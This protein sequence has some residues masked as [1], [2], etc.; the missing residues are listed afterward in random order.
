MSRYNTTEEKMNFTFINQFDTIAASIL[1]TL[2]EKNDQ[3]QLAGLPTCHQL[4]SISWH[5]LDSFPA[6][7]ENQF[8]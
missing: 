5:L 6:I 1:Q 8:L 2:Q 7:G 4:F 3:L